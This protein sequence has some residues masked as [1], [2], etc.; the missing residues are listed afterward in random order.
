MY[1][2]IIRNGRVVDPAGSV[3][4][5]ADIAVED[6]MIAGIGDY[7]KEEGKN[8]IDASGCIVTPG[9]V[10]HHAHLYPLAPLMGLPAEAVCFANGVTTAVDAGSLGTDFYEK[11]REFIHD[12]RLRIRP[13]LNVVPAGL[14]TVPAA[15]ENPDPTLFDEKKIRELFEKY[16]G[17]FAGL[18][19]RTSREIVKE[20]GYGPLRETVRIAQEVGTSVMVHCTNPPGT[21]EELVDCLRPGDVLTH[22][23]MDR[24]STILD[25][26]GHIKKE[27]AAARERG[28]LFEAADGKAHFSFPVAE[29]AFKEGFFPDIIATDLTKGNMYSR[30]TV[31]SLAMQLSRY[32]NMGMP[33]DRVLS[34]MTANPAKQLGQ[35]GRIGC[36]S[37]GACADIAVFRPVNRPVEFGD[38]AYDNHCTIR[39]GTLL[40]QPVLTVRGGDMVYRDVTF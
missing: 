5:T 35:S 12:S 27:V 29:A 34:C 4:K 36:L 16:P 2:L 17:E 7:R 15:L 3:D 19:I 38:H 39:T 40:Y 22:M 13:Y 28:V 23:Y 10:E 25:E 24:G 11:N 33:F 26:R 18:K 14:S 20:L 31:F 6:G 21:M 37:P 32:V 30:P 1:Q 8:I 9:L